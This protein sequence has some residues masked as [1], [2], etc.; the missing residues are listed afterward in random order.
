MNYL[1]HAYFTKGDDQVLAG[2]VFGDFVKGNIDNTGFPDKIKEG[3]KL[4][5]QMDTLCDRQLYFHRLKDLLGEEY[6]H[7][8]G[9]ITDIFIDHLL[10]V[11]W[12][13]YSSISLEDFASLTYLRVSRSREFFPTRFIR[14]FDYME[15]E[16]WFLQYREPHTLEKI[17]KRLETRIGNN[18]VLHTS[19]RSLTRSH[20]LFPEYFYGFM[21]GMKSELYT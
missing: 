6:G 20:Q 2:N 17:L 21:E 16:N 13:Q 5:R 15:T 9:I 7:Y 12:S 4:H 14:V 11:N 1:G 19:V 8:K 18:T 10:A 3:L